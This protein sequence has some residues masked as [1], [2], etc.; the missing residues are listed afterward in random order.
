[1]NLKRFFLFTLMLVFLAQEVEAESRK[2]LFYRHP[3]RPEV[4]STTP[5]KDEMGMAYIPVYADEAVRTDK[6]VRSQE[7]EKY[8]CPMHPQVVSDKPGDCSICHMRLV[9]RALE[10]ELKSDPRS[11]CLF[12]NCPMEKAGALCP[13]LIVGKKGETV[14][15]PYCRKK[16]KMQE[17][18][19][20]SLLPAGYASILISPQK[21]QLIGMRTAP[22]RKK[23]LKHSI[24]AAARVA[25]DPDLY[26]AQIDYLREYRAAQGTLRNRELAFKNLQDSRWEAPRIEVAKSKLILMGMDEDSLHELVENAKADE[27]L[28]YLKPDGDVWV[29]VYVLESEVPLLRKGDAV[30]IEVPSMP[31]K[32][33]EGT[34]HSIG[35]AID[36]ATRRVHMH[37]RLK[38]DG[39]LKP[40]MFLNAVIESL[41]GEGL[42]VPE[43]AV[44][45]T[46]KTAIVFIDKGNGV[47]EPREVQLGIKAGSDY[48]VR[49]GLAEGESVVVNGNF[50]VDS[51]SKLKA[52]I[53][54]AAA[55][56][57]GEKS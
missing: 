6:A 27:A 25:Y 51:E 28:L 14:E 45:F 9:R 35:S 2:I 30:R 56:R 5:D 3:M 39:F 15:C 19:S 52:S 4:T 42:A 20:A 11:V 10:P 49:Q 26:Q 12:H 48:E 36:P 40:E 38:N 55:L 50:L 53:E 1:M 32:T 7:P 54:Q 33:Y 37:V 8:F 21:Q 44:F 31:G 17:E 41:T 18:L 47:F 16:I 46:G 13:M 29:F 34:I 57:T 22:V 23:E 24:T 43:E